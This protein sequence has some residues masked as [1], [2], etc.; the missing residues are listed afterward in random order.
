MGSDTNNNTY[1][2]MKHFYY[3]KQLNKGYIPSDKVHYKNEPYESYSE[4][5]KMMK[6]IE[7]MYKH[8][9]NCGSVL[10]DIDTVIGG[11]L[12]RSSYKVIDSKVKPFYVNINYD[13]IQVF[14]HRWNWE[15]K[16]KI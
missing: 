5:Y 14:I 2:N 3:K 11:Y 4:M 7:N 16:I 10:L 9:M 12:D 8:D 13:G 1:I 15:L 6:T